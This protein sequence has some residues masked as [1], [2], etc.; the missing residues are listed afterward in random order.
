MLVK[1]ALKSYQVGRLTLFFSGLKLPKNLADC[2]LAEDTRHSQ[3]LLSFFA[4]TTQLYSFHEH[5]EHAKEGQA[6]PFPQDVQTLYCL[7]TATLLP[8]QL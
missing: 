8:L 1:F 2:I 4:I 3:K 7:L 5:N 6:R